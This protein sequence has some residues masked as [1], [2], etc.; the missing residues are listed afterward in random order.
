[1]LLKTV[2]SWVEPAL[3]YTPNPARVEYRPF[4][5]REREYDALRGQIQRYGVGS[6]VGSKRLRPGDEQQSRNQAA[7]TQRI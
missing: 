5:I 3:M 1:M 2:V 6:A 7:R 4:D